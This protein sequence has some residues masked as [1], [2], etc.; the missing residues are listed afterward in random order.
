VVFDSAGNLYGTTLGGGV[1]DAGAV[2][3]LMNTE[4]GWTENTLQSFSEQGNNG[5]T[6]AA[7]L[8]VDQSNNLFGATS[9]GGVG[10]G[11]TVFELLQSGGG[12]SLSLLYSLSGGL[13]GPQASLV[14]DSAGNIYGSTAS[15]DTG[16]FLS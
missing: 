6:V 1:Y 15:M 3:Q 9:T 13:F 14:M 4:N 12:W 10:N 5:Y 7:G 16:M 8:I 11:G 2:F